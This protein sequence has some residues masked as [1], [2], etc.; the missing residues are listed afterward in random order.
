MLIYLQ[1]KASSNTDST[2]CNSVG[3]IVQIPCS[4]YEKL[5]PSKFGHHNSFFDWWTSE[6]SI[7]GIIMLV[8]LCIGY[9]CAVLRSSSTAKKIIKETS[10]IGKRLYSFTWFFFS[11]QFMTISFY[12]V[13]VL[14]PL[15][16]LPGNPRPH[17]STSWVYVLIGVLA[18][19][20]DRTLRVYR[21]A[22]WETTVV[23]ARILP[24]QV[25][26]L[27]LLKPR[28]TN[29]WRAPGFNYVPGQYAFLN[30]P[31]ISFAEWHPFT[32]TSV[33]SDNFV[34]FHIKSAGDWTALLHSCI[35]KQLADFLLHYTY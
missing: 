9:P 1:T 11:H 12:I 24:G 17:A 35:S 23:D 29:L 33:P 32:I 3:G 15:P 31:Q 18:Y 22:T 16:G 20:M 13:L 10:F 7:T 21:Q 26:E 27:K 2:L 25:L 28:N 19:V 34:M 14:H 8:I 30:V 6:T 4:P 5:D